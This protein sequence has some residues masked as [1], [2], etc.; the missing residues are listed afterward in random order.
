[1]TDFPEPPHLAKDL[2]STFFGR[3]YDVLAKK[4]DDETPMP[5]KPNPG[6]ESW[7]QPIP[8]PEVRQQ[9][10]A[11]A[12]VDLSHWRSYALDGD[13]STIPAQPDGPWSVLQDKA[14][15][16][17]DAKDL[18]DGA[19]RDMPRQ[20]DGRGSD[21]AQGYLT[22][23][24]DLVDTYCRGG[25]PASCGNVYQVAYLVQAA[26]AAAV[27]F[28]HDLYNLAR[29]AS[30]E[31]DKLEQGGSLDPTSIG[32][33]IVAVASAAGSIA[34]PAGALV[35]AE[36]ASLATSAAFAGGV[37]SALGTLTSAAINKPAS[38]SHPVGGRDP[39]EIMR[40]LA[41]AT[42][43]AASKYSEA[44]SRLGQHMSRVWD[45]LETQVHHRMK[46]PR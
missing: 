5:Y 32:L 23:T 2:D 28:K 40:S 37:L 3:C 9:E 43:Q 35:A 21:H 26:Y 7:S 10:V 18:M 39:R 13:V 38:N 24:R 45:D 44:A 17:G 42:D 20:W 30:D 12:M 4:V 29:Q 14:A 11:A 22:A 25:Q 34:G 19:V 36:S 8:Q 46:R 31:L 15:D 6:K 27:A 33:V 1:M 41:A 16:L